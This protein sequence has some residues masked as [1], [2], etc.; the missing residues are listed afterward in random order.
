MGHKYFGGHAASLK[1]DE[2][3]TSAQYEAAKQEWAAAH[4][5]A[6]PKEY[7]KAIREIADRLGY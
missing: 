1:N 3:A 6:T 2:W 4:P 7:E 5:E